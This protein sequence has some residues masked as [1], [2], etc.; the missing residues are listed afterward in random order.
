[1]NFCMS[2]HHYHDR[3]T[4]RPNQTMEKTPH[5]SMGKTLHSTR[6]P[7]G[8]PRPPFPSAPA[9]APPLSP[10]GDSTPLCADPGAG[11]CARSGLALRRG[12]AEARV[13]DEPS[14]SLS[15]KALA[16]ASAART[17][18]G[19]KVEEVRVELGRR[20]V[21]GPGLGLGLGLEESL[22]YEW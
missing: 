6:G 2:T 8:P 17:L 22:M 3:P 10:G 19:F 9:P 7:L 13:G 16:C 15:L 11:S 18:C 14:L 5:S 21:A 4:D 12:I 1:M 20:C